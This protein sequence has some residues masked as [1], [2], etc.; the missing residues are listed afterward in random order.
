MEAMIRVSKL[1]VKQGKVVSHANGA[2]ILQGV[3]LLLAEK[4]AP[5]MTMEQLATYAWRHFEETFKQPLSK[6]K[7]SQQ[8]YG[9]NV[10]KVLEVACTDFSKFGILIRQIAGKLRETDWDTDPTTAR[11]LPC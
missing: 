3:S 7:Q 4:G 5:A 11:I 2:V 8:L 9:K 6:T 10:F 1:H